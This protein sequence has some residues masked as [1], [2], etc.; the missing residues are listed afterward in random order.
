M[1]HEKTEHSLKPLNKK[2][3][4]KPTICG[5][6]AQVWGRGDLGLVPVLSRASESPQASTSQ[7]FTGFKLPQVAVSHTH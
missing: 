6:R 1:L 5:A 7:P 4:T 3:P 2:E